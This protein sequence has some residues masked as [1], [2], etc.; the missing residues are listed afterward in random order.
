M[1]KKICASDFGENF[2]W[3]V[4][5]AAFQIEGAHDKH[6]KG[7]S[8]WDMFTLKKGKIHKNQ[9]AKV[10]C[11]FYHRYKEDIL[12]MKSMNIE[13]FR[14]SIAWSRILPTGTGTINPDG[15]NFYNNVIDFC[16][17]LNITPWITLYHWDLPYELES[18]GGWTNRKILDWFT[19][20]V[21]VCAKAFG[22]RVKHWMVLNEPMVFTGGGYFLGVHAPGKKR[23][24]N[25]LPAVHHAQLSQAVGGRALRKLITDA[26]IGTTYSCSYIVP[27]NNSPKNLKTARKADALLNRLFIE[28][29][30]GLGYPMNDLPVLKRLAPYILPGDMEKSRFNFDFVGIQNYTR[31]IIEHS[32]FVPY[33]G[34]KIIKAPKRNVRTTLMEW[35]VY[36]PS[37]YE[38]IR[39]YDAYSNMPDIIITE[40]GAAFKDVFKKGKVKDKK[41]KKFLKDHL[42]QVLK[43]KNEGL[44]I[45]GY[46]VWTFTDNFEWAEGY[47]P[48]FGLVH[49]DFGTQKRTIKSSGRWYMKFLKN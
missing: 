28:P 43:A 23:M 38:M 47:N 10:S 13:N 44:N 42:E 11:D 4:S 21:E 16:L 32:Y 34:A 45:H 9:T 29:V 37:I 5:T 19:E 48:G 6:G 18:K 36:P 41:R 1:S 20:F 40:N 33:I 25:F 46:F 3:G 22:D 8:I 31:E 24:K 12:L 26:K 14:F 30:L 49:V 27:K 35:E 2:I 39:K 17:S 15:I 7:P